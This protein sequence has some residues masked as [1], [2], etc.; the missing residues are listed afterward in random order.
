MS[1]AAVGF[2][3]VVGAAMLAVACNVQDSA[4]RVHGYL[5]DNVGVNRLLTPITVQLTCGV[6]AAVMAGQVIIALT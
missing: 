2:D 5:A 6:L 1:W 3:L 4:W